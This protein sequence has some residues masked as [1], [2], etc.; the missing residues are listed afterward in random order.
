MKRAMFRP[1]GLK[2]SFHVDSPWR[3]KMSVFD[4]ID[5]AAGAV[6]PKSVGKWADASSLGI[7]NFLS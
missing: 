5:T 1:P 7:L 4:L 2:V 6:P 3:I